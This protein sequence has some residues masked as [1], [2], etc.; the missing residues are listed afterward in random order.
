MLNSFEDFTFDNCLEVMFWL[1]NL[2][3]NVAGFNDS[4]NVP[5]IEALVRFV[6]SMQFW[7]LLDFLSVFLD[8]DLHS[9]LRLVSY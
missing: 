2:V 8:R 6:I 7:T 9:V 4:I 3:A 1:G 5:R